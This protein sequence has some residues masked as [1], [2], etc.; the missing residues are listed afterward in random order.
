MDCKEIFEIFREFINLYIVLIR[1]SN[2]SNFMAPKMKIL[3]R[4]HWSR[5]SLPSQSDL[6]IYYPSS[7][8]NNFF[9]WISNLSNFM[10]PNSKSFASGTLEPCFIAFAIGSS[11]LLSVVGGIILFYL[12][13]E[14]FA[15]LHGD[16]RSHEGIATLFFYFY[17]RSIGNR[18]HCTCNRIYQI[19]PSS[20]I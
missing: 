14:Y 9:I 18:V 13:R 4:E 7:A 20:A 16:R 2:S 6:P 12:E 8:V 3:P 5:V 19:C 1:I 15:N 10:A 11:N 17:L